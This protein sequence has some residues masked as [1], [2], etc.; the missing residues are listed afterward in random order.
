MPGLSPKLRKI[1]RKVGVKVVFKSGANLSTLL[2]NKN[3]SKLPDNS[4]PGVYKIPCKKHPENPYIGETKLQIRTRNEIHK[5][6]VIKEQ[7][8]QSGVAFHSSLCK[9]VE[10]DAIETLKVEKNR[11][12]RKVREAL[13]IQF[14]KCDPDN[15][16]MNKDWG[17][18]VKTKFWTPFLSYLRKTS[19]NVI[20]V[21]TPATQDE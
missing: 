18:Y 4:H 6:Y 8:D 11:F 7:W 19:N 9:E 17:D 21:D 12:D 20:P 14:H 15:G 10:W 2:T 16:G 13:E 3:K 1:Y 5:G